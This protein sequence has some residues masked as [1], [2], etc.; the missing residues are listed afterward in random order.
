MLAKNINLYKEK[1]VKYHMYNKYEIVYTVQVK[2]LTGY[3]VN[4][5]EATHEDLIKLTSEIYHKSKGELHKL[6]SEAEKHGKEELLKETWRQDVEERL[7]FQKDQKKNGK[8]ESCFRQVFELF[9]TV[10][11]GKKGNR[12][13]L[14]TIRMGKCKLHDV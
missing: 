9:C 5:N 3:D 14:I 4:V 13:S 10:V 7:S 6:L 12:W 11:S 1:L 2:R 8:T